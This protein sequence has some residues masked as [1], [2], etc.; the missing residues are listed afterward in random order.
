[1]T[2]LVIQPGASY[3][4]ERTAPRPSFGRLDQGSLYEL[5]GAGSRGGGR[6]VQDQPTPPDHVAARLGPVL[7]DGGIRSPWWS[8]HW[9]LF[10][11]QRPRTAPRCRVLR[12]ARRLQHSVPCRCPP[13]GSLHPFCTTDP[14]STRRQRFEGPLADC[15]RPA[16]HC[17]RSPVVS[18]STSVAPSA[19]TGPSW[20]RACT[21]DSDRQ[22]CWPARWSVS[23]PLAVSRPR[24]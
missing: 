15:F 1:M 12:T 14:I 24:P 9:Q 3:V 6:V 13:P 20:P 11:D 5:R 22:V 16:E 17:S 18:R 19:A 21:S 23:L 10:G 4:V 8:H 2:G 7:R